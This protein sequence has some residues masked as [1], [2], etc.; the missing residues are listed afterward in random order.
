MMRSIAFPP[1]CTGSHAVIA[2]VAAICNQLPAG[3]D[4]DVRGFYDRPPPL[5]L[6]F[7]VCAKRLCCL[8]LRWRDHLAQ[9]LK[10]AA[11]VA[12]RECVHGRVRECSDNVLWRTFRHPQA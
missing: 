4:S 8:L 12:V 11:D 9:V 3:F 5:D 2:G 7:M 10:P 1:A 6:G